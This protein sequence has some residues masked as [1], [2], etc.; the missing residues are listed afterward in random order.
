VGLGEFGNQKLQEKAS[1]EVES[2]QFLIPKEENRH[3]E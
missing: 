2:V 1:M 3:D